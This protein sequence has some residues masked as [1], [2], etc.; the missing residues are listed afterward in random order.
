MQ[1]KKAGKSKVD[2]FSPRIHSDVL[3]ESLFGNMDMDDNI[4]DIE[5]QAVGQLISSSIDGAI[6][7][8]KLV[9]ENR[10]SNADKLSDN[11]IYD[12]YTKSFRTIL[13]STNGIN[14]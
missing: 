10:K 9:I 1:K 11:D 6:D 7:L 5:A 12:I 2:K 13:T 4:P 14:S 8:T 3:F